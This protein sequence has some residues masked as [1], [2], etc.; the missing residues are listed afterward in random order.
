LQPPIGEYFIK[1]GILANMELKKMIENLKIHNSKVIK[2]A[3]GL[4]NFRF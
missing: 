3:K 1:Q 4:F 2:R